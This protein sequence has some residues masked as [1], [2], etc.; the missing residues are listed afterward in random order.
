MIIPSPEIKWWDKVSAVYDQI[1]KTFCF[2][3]R[4]LEGY[5]YKVKHNN[6]FFGPLCPLPSPAFSILLQ[7]T[8]LV[9]FAV[10]ALVWLAQMKNMKIKSM[11]ARSE[12][13]LW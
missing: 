7:R 13:T 2:G 10:Q 6:L 8:F 5:R 3:K 12:R 4:S 11:I 1:L 9:Q